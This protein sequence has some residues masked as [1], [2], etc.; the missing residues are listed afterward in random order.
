MAVFQAGVTAIVGLVRRVLVQDFGDEI[1]EQQSF[2]R[3]HISESGQV[4]PQQF[5][6]LKAVD[7]GKVRGYIEFHKIGG[8]WKL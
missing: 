1:H 2:A 4:P 5:F 6:E 8:R 7:T 3:V